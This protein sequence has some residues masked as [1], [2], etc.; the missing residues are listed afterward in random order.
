MFSDG[1]LVAGDAGSTPLATLR[2]NVGQQ[3]IV[4]LEDTYYSEDG[5]DFVHVKKSQAVYMKLVVSVQ[6]V[7]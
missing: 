3:A 2:G 5:H 4:V 1:A 7:T 6:P